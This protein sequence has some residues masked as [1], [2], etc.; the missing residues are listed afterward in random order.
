MEKVAIEYGDG[1]FELALEEK[2]DRELLGQ[3]REL[4]AILRA[5]PSYTVL[6]QSRNVSGEEKDRL[7]DEAFAGRLHPYLCNFL[8]LMCD[9]GYFDRVPACCARF[10]DRFCQHYGIRRVTVR[11]AAELDE[12]QKIKVTKSVE[13][14]LG[15]QAQILF[16]VDPSLVAGLRIE[17]EGVLIEN[18]AKSVLEGLKRHLSSSVSGN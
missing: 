8:H 11:S 9:R 13:K 4:R 1:L 7:L 6:M 18:S 5:E 15:C 2:I 3:T 14:K 16:T 10:E 17:A 12:E